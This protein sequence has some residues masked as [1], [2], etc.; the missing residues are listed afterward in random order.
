MTNANTD[1]TFEAMLQRF[2][3]TVSSLETDSLSLEDAI[4]KYETAVELAQQCAAI[5]ERAELRVSEIERKI[6]DMESN[7]E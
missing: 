6:E 4:D 3:E 1:P 5:L 2:D 7:S